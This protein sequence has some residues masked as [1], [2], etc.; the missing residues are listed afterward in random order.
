MHTQVTVF[1]LQLAQLVQ[2]TLRLDLLAPFRDI[3]NA[4]VL[5]VG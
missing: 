4:A 1:A 5:Q 2:Q 3:V